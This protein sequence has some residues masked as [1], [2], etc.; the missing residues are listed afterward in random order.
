MPSKDD[1]GFPS[2][3]RRENSGR[4][5]FS[6]SLAGS[7]RN[8]SFDGRVA[9]SNRPYGTKATDDFI[10]EFAN[11]GVDVCENPKNL[12]FI[13][14]HCALCGRIDRKNDLD[15]LIL[16]WRFDAHKC[17]QLIDDSISDQTASRK[18]IG[19]RERT[20]VFHIDL[21]RIAFERGAAF[22]G[23]AGGFLECRECDWA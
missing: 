6:G 8:P 14:V 16:L 1:A 18:P 11:S 22:S 2:E 21:V 5:G 3:L 17:R 7:L 15:H 19:A 13:S 9:Q 10:A 12:A 23:L 20:W 4:P